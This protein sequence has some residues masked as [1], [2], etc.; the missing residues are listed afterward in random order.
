MSRPWLGRSSGLRERFLRW[1]RSSLPGW[2]LACDLDLVEYKQVHVGP[3]WTSYQ[4]VV[5]AEVTPCGWPLPGPR[6]EGGSA[7]SEG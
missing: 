5:L 3:G 6:R 2:A 1:H 7:G 4:P